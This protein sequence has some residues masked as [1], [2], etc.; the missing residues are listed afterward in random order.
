MLLMLV[1]FFCGGF[2]GRRGFNAESLSDFLPSVIGTYVVVTCL[3]LLAGLSLQELAPMIGFTS[4]GILAS[5]VS[6]LILLR[7]F[8]PKT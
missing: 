5:I 6:S 8:P 7:R 1:M 4:V 2:V 3:G